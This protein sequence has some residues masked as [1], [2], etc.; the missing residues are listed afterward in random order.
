MAQELQCTVSDPVQQGEGVQAHVSYRVSTKA[1][2]R[3]SPLPKAGG[4]FPC[5]L[6]EAREKFLFP[7]APSC[8]QRY[9]ISDGSSAASSAAS[10]TS[11]SCTSGFPTRTQARPPPFCPICLSVAAEALYDIPAVVIHA[12]HHFTPNPQRADGSPRSPRRLGPASAAQASS[13]PP[14]QRKTSLRSSSITRTS[15]RRALYA[16]HLPPPAPRLLSPSAASAHRPPR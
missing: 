13:S 1:R 2:A 10:R 11:R 12:S 15:S 6:G 3:L 4:E 9:R 7:L 14:F 16:V 5:T 8:R